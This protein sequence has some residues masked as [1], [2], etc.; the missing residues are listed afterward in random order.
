MFRIISILFIF[1]I[2]FC[3]NGL[4]AQ[5]TIYEED[6]DSYADGT[7]TG[8][9]WNAA[10]GK[11]DGN[12]DWS[13]GVD[14]GRFSIENIEGMT[15]GCPNGTSGDNSNFATFGSF[16]ITNHCD[17][18]IDFDIDM[19][20]T[21]TCADGGS[22]DAIFCPPVAGTG[23]DVVQVEA[24]IDGVTTILYFGCGNVVVTD[25]RNAP[26]N[27][28]NITIRIIGGTTA[29][30]QIYTVDNIVMTGF[31]TNGNIAITADKSNPICEEESITL[32]AQTG[33]SGSWNTGETTQSITKT[34]SPGSTTYTFTQTSGCVVNRGNYAVVVTPSINADAGN[35][36]EICENQSVTLEAAIGGTSYTWDDPAATQSRFLIVSP[37]STRL[38]SVTVSNGTCSDVDEVL[39]T[40]KPNPVVLTGSDETICFGDDARLSASGADSYS[41]IPGGA[42]GPSP[43]VSPTSSTIYTVIGTTNGC[44]STNAMAVIVNPLP[45]A[46]ISGL[47][48]ICEGETITLT[49]SGGDEYE[50]SSTGST[51][52]MIK[53][54]PSSDMSYSLTVTD[55]NGCKDDDQILISVDPAFSTNIGNDQEICQGDTIVLNAIGGDTFRW[56]DGS[57]DQTLEVH[58][59]A[60]TTYSVIATAGACT[61][62]DVVN[63]TVSESYALQT[64][65]DTTICSGSSIELQAIS[66]PDVFITWED[67]STESTFEVQPMETTTYVVQTTDGVCEITRNIEVAI[68][69]INIEILASDKSPCLGDSITLTVNTNGILTWPDGLSEPTRKISPTVDTTVVVETESNLLCSVK[70]SI[71]ITVNE[72]PDI[73]IDGSGYFCENG[74]TTLNATSGLVSYLWNDDDTSAMKAIDSA[75]I[76]TVTGTDANGCS[77]QASIDI[78]QKSLPIPEVLGAF[79]FCPGSSTELSISENYPSITWN[80]NG[81]ISNGSMLQVSENATVMVIVG[82]EFSCIGDTSFFVEENPDLS[83]SISGSLTFCENGSTTLDAGDGFDVYLWSTDGDQ[84]QITVADAGEYSVTVSTDDGCS[85]RDTVVVEAFA[86][87]TVQING[88]LG[89]CV[90][91]STELSISDF[92]IIA[93]SDGSNQN[94]ISVKTAGPIS[95]N[96][97]DAN[98]CLASDQKLLFEQ[99]LPEVQIVGDTIF[100]AG[101]SVRHEVMGN[102]SLP[103]W[104]DG[105]NG[106]DIY[107][108]TSQ[109]SSVEVIDD[110]GCINSTTVVVEEKALPTPS[111]AA[112]AVVCEGTAVTIYSQSVHEKYTWNGQ[113]GNDSLE[114]QV[115]GTYQLEVE[116]ELGCKAQDQVN[117]GTSTPPKVDFKIAM[118]LCNSVVESRTEPTRLS[119][120][121]V[122]ASTSAA[123]TWSTNHTNINL[124]SLPEINF[125]GMAPGAYEFIYTTNDAVAPCENT[126]AVLTVDILDCQCPFV[127]FTPID[128]LCSIGGMLDLSSIQSTDFEGS[129]QVINGPSSNMPSISNDI[130]DA[131]GEMP[132]DYEIEFRLNDGIAPLGCAETESVNLVVADHI[133]AAIE[134]IDPA[135]GDNPAILQLNLSG[136]ALFDVNIQ[137]DDGGIINLVNVADGHQFEVQLGTSSGFMFQSIESDIRTCGFE[138][139]QNLYMFSAGNL[140]AEIQVSQ[141]GNYE[142]SCSDALDG[143]AA[144]LIS[145]GTAPY[146]YNWNTGDQSETLTNLAEGTYSVTVEDDNGCDFEETISITA[147]PAKLIEIA[148]MDPRCG[149]GPGSLLLQPKPDI[150][151]SADWEFYIDGVLL[152]QRDPTTILEGIEIG[153]HTFEAISPLGCIEN[154]DFEI[155]DSN[156]GKIISTDDVTVTLGQS[157]ILSPNINFD[158]ESIEWTPS[159][160]L[161]DS[162]NA[163]VFVE[164]PLSNTT[165]NIQVIDNEGCT[166]N[167]EILVNVD[168]GRSL[169]VPTGFSPNGDNNNDALIIHAA[170]AVQ[171][172]NSIS[173]FNRSGEQVF[174]GENITPNEPIIWDWTFRNQELPLGQYIWQAEA[175]FIDGEI[176]DFNGKFELIK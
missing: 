148:P 133:D 126:T 112:P 44:S 87:P 162:S 116:D 45:T 33:G 114:I 101:D 95:V 56:S 118:E 85:G 16:D 81:T 40:V 30:T 93:W 152:S 149:Q 169:L 47:S 125:D 99:A 54:S 144:I 53:V 161:S 32:T 160:Y 117:I 158:Y 68:D 7:T 108:T 35:D 174:L 3:S 163:V 130:F 79:T 147:P 28:D 132:G 159:T 41:W 90:G 6:F 64:T 141:F 22:E 18:R 103:T 154:H 71:A 14:N 155:K 124:N 119:L 157:T 46:D 2:C 52:S 55:A 17:V 100:C 97:E 172:I 131:N 109:V 19:S 139:P 98:G 25:N 80:L 36:K 31:P 4:N 110:F 135:C 13:F 43:T 146:T 37:A 140:E 78:E 23:R 150:T 165:Y 83:P 24:I 73:A 143:T 104:H 77:N 9:A 27:G 76:Y 82:D 39:V 65:S 58:P 38:Y 8:G 128:T 105:S 111:I 51:S 168:K 171:S 175:T 11:C 61:A 34:P 67:G 122:F 153:M 10:S 26:L 102:F 5:V 59:E 170:T 106:S 42:T 63:I 86:N 173:I 115:G 69:D 142:L 107:I 88:V 127:Q 57:T 72:I 70:D 145:E 123:G 29:L 60:E 94:T 62:T 156:L 1:I 21:L 92:P 136:G 75:G 120:D 49:G 167:A 15:C 91:D 96:V 89:F 20:G 151:N 48:P 137:Q 113:I 138:S 121:T 134:L 166:F 129:W 12:P 50:W 164:L 84:S 74:T 176:V 66:H